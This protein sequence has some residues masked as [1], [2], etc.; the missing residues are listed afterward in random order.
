LSAVTFGL[1]IPFVFGGFDPSGP[2]SREWMDH[3]EV[4]HVDSLWTLDQLNGRAATPEPMTLLSY[5][6]AM[7]TRVRLG[8]AVMVGLARGPIVTAKETTTLD[9][10]SRGRLDVGLGLGDLR[11]LAGYGLAADKLATGPLFDEYTQTLIQLWTEGR[12]S[13]DGPAWRFDDVGISPQPMQQPHPPIWFGGGGTASLRRAVRWGAGWIGAGR[14]STVEH[15]DLVSRLLRLLDERPGG[16]QGFG[17]AKRVYVVVTDD[18]SAGERAVEAWFG[19]FYN[20]PELGASVSV[21]GS[22][23]RCVDAIGTLVDA[24]T[25]HILLHPLVETVDQFDRVTTEVIP[26]LAASR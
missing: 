6:A 7:S 23:G 17:I 24:G 9:W 21:W 16:R 19:R 13:S 2:T 20:R 8:V 14:H 11:H 5:A 3:L 1:S 4:D 22:P 26:Q 25:N 18:D 12:V 10:L 15:L